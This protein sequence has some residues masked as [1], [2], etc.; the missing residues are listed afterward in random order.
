LSHRTDWL[1]KLRGAFCN[2]VHAAERVLIKP[3][4]PKPM[5]DIGVIILLHIE[6]KCMNLIHIVCGVI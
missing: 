3:V 5:G 4:F 2:V 6:K 1:S